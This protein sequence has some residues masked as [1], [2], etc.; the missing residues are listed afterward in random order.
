MMTD[1]PMYTLEYILSCRNGNKQNE[2][3]VYRAQHDNSLGKWRLNIPLEETGYWFLSVFLFE[4]GSFD[5]YSLDY[6]AASDSHYEFRITRQEAIALFGASATD[7]RLDQVLIK[8]LKKTAVA[9]YWKNWGLILLR[10]ITTIR[11]GINML[12]ALS[13]IPLGGAVSTGMHSL[14]LQ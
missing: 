10:S 2:F 4:N 6:E 3:G 12:Y 13:I 1:K 9:D 14:A 11:G 8:E 5:R 7:E